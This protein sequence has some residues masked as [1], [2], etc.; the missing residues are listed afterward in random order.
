MKNDENEKKEAGENEEIKWI[1]DDPVPFPDDENSEVVKLQSGES[2]SG[3]IIDIL[4]STKWKGRKIY[5]IKEQNNDITKVLLG[6]TVLDRQM[7]NKKIGDYVKIERLADTPTDKGNP[8]QN[9][10][11]YS[12]TN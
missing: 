3:T 11:T 6:T 10:K 5:K 2:L 4:D 9:W 12:R 8:L 7:S 1:E